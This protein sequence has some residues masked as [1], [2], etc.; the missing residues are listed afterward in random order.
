MA[1]FQHGLFSL[2]I[3]TDT[4]ESIRGLIET[5]LQEGERDFIT[6]ARLRDRLPANVL[7]RLG[8]SDRRAAPARVAAAIAPL[9]GDR[10]RLYG[11]GRSP[12]VGRHRAPSAFVE[13]AIRKRPGIS[14]KQLVQALPLT[15]RTVLDAIN[16]LI[17]SGAVVC[18]LG[19]GHLPK[20]H[21]AAPSG[22]PGTSAAPADGSDRAAFGA[23]CRALARDRGLIR[24]HAL[25]A[26]LDWPR[27]RFDDMLRE[28]MAAYAIELHGGDPSSMTES[29]IEGAY[30]DPNGLLYIT[31][32][33][34]GDGHDG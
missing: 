30:R 32:T 21:P 25:R 12:V 31:L 11:G 10:L 1:R 20:L 33:W 4:P 26:Y 15:Q 2:N 23:A 5:A 16:Q 19:P 13:A 14:S 8:L 9:L 6:V 24:I 34:W 27:Q 17:E 29:Q 7:R 3:D 18:T 22:V 28:M